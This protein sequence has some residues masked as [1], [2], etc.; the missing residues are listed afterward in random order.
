VPWYLGWRVVD[1][2]KKKRRTVQKQVKGGD[3]KAEIRSITGNAMRETTIDIQVKQTGKSTLCRLSSYLGIRRASLD[4]LRVG[5]AGGVA[6]VD[7][8][9]GI[10]G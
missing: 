8:V 9:P 5:C 4:V 3:I 7:G 10:G 6:R 2:P 1:G